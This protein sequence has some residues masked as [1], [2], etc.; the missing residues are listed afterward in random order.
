MFNIRNDY[1]LKYIKVCYCWD[2]GNPHIVEELGVEFAFEELVEPVGQVC[3][4]QKDVLG[5]NI[6]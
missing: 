6:L 4:R 2:D 1:P 3:D 5:S